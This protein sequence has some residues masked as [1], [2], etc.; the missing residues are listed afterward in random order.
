MWQ[1]SSL[2]NEMHCGYCAEKA[3]LSYNDT[4]KY[5]STQKTPLLP[6]LPTHWLLQGS[7]SFLARK[8]ASFCRKET[9]FRAK[10]TFFKPDSP[11]LSVI[12]PDLS[13]YFVHTEI[14]KLLQKKKKGK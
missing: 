8:Q 14:E 2:D 11:I 9:P 3:I 1:K 4:L 6:L 12:F 10:T 7:S 13:V 5:L